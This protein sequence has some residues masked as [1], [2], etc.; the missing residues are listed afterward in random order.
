MM[1]STLPEVHARDLG[2]N[3]PPQSWF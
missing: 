1:I 2:E 3:E